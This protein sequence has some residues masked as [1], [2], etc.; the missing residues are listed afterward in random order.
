MLVVFLMD[1]STSSKKIFDRSKSKGEPSGLIHGW[2]A[3][4]CASRACDEC[5]AILM[6]F[7][8]HDVI[9]SDIMPL[10]T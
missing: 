10:G 1:E 5:S 2:G 7:R 3:L 6:S 9:L 8:W 4:Q